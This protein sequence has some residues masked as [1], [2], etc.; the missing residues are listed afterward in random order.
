MKILSLLGRI[1]PLKLLNN[2]K[3]KKGVSKVASLLDIIS[4]KL[5][6]QIAINFR[7]I[8]AFILLSVV[9]L[10]IIGSISLGSFKSAMKSNIGKYSKQLI[11]QVQVN[12]DSQ[13]KKIQDIGENIRN[14]NYYKDYENVTL[15]PPDPNDPDSKALDPLMIQSDFNGY[16]SGL[17]LGSKTI[18]NVCFYSAR[19]EDQLGSYQLITKKSAL[20]KKVKKLP[21]Q[22]NNYWV[23]MSK[24]EVDS[25]VPVKIPILFVNMYNPEMGDSV[26]T[27]GI[28]QLNPKSDIF[29]AILDNIDLGVKG[30]Q[31]YV[32]DDKN[33]ILS[34]KSVSGKQTNIGKLIDTEIKISDSLNSKKGAEKK[35]VKKTKGDS[36]TEEGQTNV[37]TQGSF[38]ANMNGQNMLVCYKYLDNG[39]KVV[40]AVPFNKLMVAIKQI[41]SLTIIL[42]III[43]ILALLISYMVTRSVSLPI[44]RINDAIGELKKGNFTKQLGVDYNDEISKFSVNFNS[45]VSN[46]QL[47]IRDITRASYDVVQNSEKISTHSLQSES[48]AEQIA[49]AVSEMATGSSEQAFESQ[50]GK[51]IMDSL[52]E[53]LNKIVENTT[54]M[55]QVTEKTKSLSENSLGVINEL[56][57]S[58]K[59]TSEVTN[60][61]ISQIVSLNHDMKQITS[62]VKVIVSISEQTNLLALNATIEAARAGEAGK[63]FAVVADEVRKLAEQ[64]KN[65]SISISSIINEIIG[66]SKEVVE[67][68][69]SAA[70]TLDK[71]MIAVGHT[72]RT[73]KNILAATEEIVTDLEKM[74]KVIKEM[75]EFKEKAISSME[76]ITIISQSSAAA[77]Q[78]INATTEEQIASSSQLADLARD[79]NS[80]A[81]EMQR[82]IQRFK[83]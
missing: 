58:A 31:F 47:M 4:E 46:V 73:F 81:E 54:T 26:P 22:S 69:N 21:A 61:I 65:A 78:E 77:S 41:T 12:I 63:G 50:K 2:H 55:Q 30:Q 52:A 83:I 11:S 40:S 8:I 79:L 37:L 75:D 45:M 34:K 6:R 23:Y 39:W 25:S 36:T 74:N 29:S 72:D 3:A 43:S 20:F 35:T 48:A 70:V 15:N 51:Q 68:A 38:Y 1:N 5:L 18:D 7:L 76:T 57:I 64:S 44:S 16:L 53:R 71:Q 9:P 13:M 59:D 14:S 82:T 32:L 17:L 19:N 10:V 67:Q 80:M 62:I 28:L 27:G 24:S 33:K 49:S 42:I 56:S 60:G 66:K